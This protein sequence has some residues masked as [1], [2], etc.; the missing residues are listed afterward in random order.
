MKRYIITLFIG[1][2]ISVI[3]IPFITACSDDVEESA[4]D[5]HLTADTGTVTATVNLPAGEVITDPS[6]C[7]VSLDDDNTYQTG[8]SGGSNGVNTTDSPG[9]TCDCEIGASSYACTVSD[10]PE[11]AYYLVGLVFVGQEGGS[12]PEAGDFK[13]YYGTADGSAPS[14][15]NAVVT[16][17]QDN[18]YMVDQAVLTK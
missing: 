1:I 9:D 4:D 13:G 18:P 6:Y 7:S 11:G 17:G 10:V 3:T 8:L 15:P 14:G 16:A 12:S 2:L 5:T